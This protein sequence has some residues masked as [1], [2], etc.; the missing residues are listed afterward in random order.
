M[1]IIFFTNLPQL[2]AIHAVLAKNLQD[3]G[4]LEKEQ[5]ANL[6]TSETILREPSGMSGLSIF[7]TKGLIQTRTINY[8]KYVMIKRH[9]HLN[10]SSGFSLRAV[11]TAAAGV[12][13]W[14]GTVSAK[15]MEFSHHFNNRVI[16][17]NLAGQIVASHGLPLG[18]GDPTGN[19]VGGDMLTTRNGLYS[20]FGFFFH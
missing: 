1:V 2:A 16:R 7:V 11:L 17:I 10:R 6:P 20:P 18:R 5:W 15:N 14:A 3:R 19:N 13:A 8:G 9:N 4:C 12:P